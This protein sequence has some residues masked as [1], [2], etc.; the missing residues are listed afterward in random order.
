MK[1]LAFFAGLVLAGLLAFS[2]PAEANFDTTFV[3]QSI[4]ISQIAEGGK[5]EIDTP[6]GLLIVE[7][8]PVKTIKREPVYKKGSRGERVEAFREYL[9]PLQVVNYRLKGFK[10]GQLTE[11]LIVLKETYSGLPPWPDVTVPVK[12][13]AF[14][15]IWALGNDMAVTSDVFPADFWQLVRQ[16]LYL[17]DELLL[18]NVI[19]LWP[20]K[21]QITVL[22]LAPVRRVSPAPSVI[23]SRD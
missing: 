18:V 21:N 4:L 22:P 15:D 5:F 11:K 3:G 14:S 13:G 19:K 23:A 9:G 10:N 16:E 17:N 2:G 7:Y 20:G 8:S 1:I 12:N 6:K